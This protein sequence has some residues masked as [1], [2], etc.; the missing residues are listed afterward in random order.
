MAAATSSS[1]FRCI[2]ATA[3]SRAATCSAPPRAPPPAVRPRPGDIRSHVSR[4]TTTQK[5]CLPLEASRPL[6]P[7]AFRLPPSAFPTPSP[8][9]A[10]FDP[11]LTF[12]LTCLTL[13]PDPSP[14]VI[15]SVVAQSLPPTD[16]A[17]LFPRSLQR[18]PFSVCP[19]SV[20]FPTLSHLIAS[21]TLGGSTGAPAATPCR[22]AHW[23]GPAGWPR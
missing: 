23:E 6:P 7:S 18:R 17:L 3:D 5:L 2:M 10:I 21:A 13:I 12:T 9:T 20:S 4:R 14:A 1:P 11:S 19:L 15:P 8:S 22:S 16:L